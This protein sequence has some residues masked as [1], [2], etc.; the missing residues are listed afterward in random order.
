MTAK[1]DA[2]NRSPRQSQFAAGGTPSIIRGGPPA[3][4]P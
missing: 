2:R 4:R 1:A 3:Y